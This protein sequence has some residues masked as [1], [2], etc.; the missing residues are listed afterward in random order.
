MKQGRAP[1][2]KFIK[3]KNYFIM[4]REKKKNTLITTTGRPGK[5]DIDVRKRVPGMESR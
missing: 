4:C 5:H 2:K 3:N 1:K